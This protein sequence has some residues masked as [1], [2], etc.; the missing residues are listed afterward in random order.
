MM[1]LLKYIISLTA[2][3]YFSFNTL[4]IFADEVVNTENF[5]DFTLE[6]ELIDGEELLK[7]NFFIIEKSYEIKSNKPEIAAV[8]SSTYTVQKGDT[9]AGIAKKFDQKEDV[10]RKNNPNVSFSSLKIGTKLTILSENGI[11]HNVKKGESISRIA[12]IYKV[13]TQNITDYNSLE[14]TNLKIGQELFI[15]DPN[16]IAIKPTV[17]SN[18]PKTTTA[19]KTVDKKTENFKMPVKWAGVS[20]KFGSRLHPV[21]KRYIQHTGVDLKAQYTQLHATKDGKVS[22]A[23]YM[24]AY[25]KIIIIKHQ[26]GYETRSAHLNDIYV[27]NGQTVKQGQVIGKTGKSGRV[28]GPHL[29]FEI[30]KGS[31]PDDPMKYLIR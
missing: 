16:L 3:L 11:Y 23:G 21:L 19:S 5:T 25:G 9:L 6:S 15:K 31:R 14:G 8:T 26:D 29:H 20:S 17:A 30:R 22:F 4:N 7:E 2:I 1:V 13:K 10:I 27:K 28:T 18:K 24:G 12:S